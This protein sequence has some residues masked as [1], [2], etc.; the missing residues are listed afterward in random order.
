MTSERQ[1][2]KTRAARPTRLAAL[3]AIGMALLLAVPATV[4]SAAPAK[5]DTLI[6]R[7]LPSRVRL[8]PGE[9]VLLI[10]NTNVTTGYSWIAQ[11]GCCA[12]GNKPVVKISDGVYAAP[13]TTDNMVGVSGTTTW[14]ITAV[15]KGKTQ[16]TVVTRPPGATNTMQD[17]TVG[18][19][20]IVVM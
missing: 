20:S 15:R 2:R 8:V 7:D 16:V 1:S 19:L 11:G 3:V 4:A 13:N 18:V 10:L 17:E 5:D 14:T 9:K 6:V 12:K